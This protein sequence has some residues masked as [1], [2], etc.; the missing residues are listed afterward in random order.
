MRT[1][2]NVSVAMIAAIIVHFASNNI[3]LSIGFAYQS[4]ETQFSPGP[5]SLPDGANAIYPA[6]GRAVALVGSDL[7]FCNN[8]NCGRGNADYAADA[9]HFFEIRSPR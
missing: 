7:W 4:F 6:P 3:L 1:T 8:C 2:R 9:C 5:R